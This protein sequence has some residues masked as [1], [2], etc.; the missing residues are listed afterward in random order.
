MA[1]LADLGVEHLTFGGS[2]TLMK[3]STTRLIPLYLDHDSIPG[4]EAGWYVLSQ[5]LPG[6]WAQIYAGPF[7]TESETQA[8]IQRMI[9]ADPALSE[10][11][12]H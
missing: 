3:G 12:T 10:L 6:D 1:T 5:P 4:A 2:F 9:A 7:A 8:L 11:S